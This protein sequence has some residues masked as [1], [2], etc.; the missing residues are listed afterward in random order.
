MGTRR[1]GSRRLRPAD[2]PVTYRDAVP[3][4]ED[5]PP[6]EP[7]DEPAGD[8][9]DPAELPIAQLG[10]SAEADESDE[11]S[12]ARASHLRLIVISAAAV[13]VIGLVVGIVLVNSSA[14]SP[15]RGEST[16]RLAAQR[17]VR[18][19]NSGDERAAAAI[20]CDTF[21]DDARAQARSGADPSITFRLREVSMQSKTSA[22]AVLLERAV[23]PGNHV[24]SGTLG[25]AVLMS[26]G[27]WLMCGR[28]D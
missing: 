1:S 20:A 21:A 23:L 16:A 5:A 25:V 12:P 19:L 18:A 27:R 14:P 17:Y 11:R 24:H 13:V 9:Y 26:G 4:F 28:L 22:T 3:E 6:G 15:G 2:G 8:P 10:A 7:D